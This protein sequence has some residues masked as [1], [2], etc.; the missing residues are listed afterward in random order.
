MPADL[1]E[2]QFA[3]PSVPASSKRQGPRRGAALV[4]VLLVILVA[5]G[6]ATAMVQMAV[7]QRRQFASD[8]RRAQADWFAQAGLDRAVAQL[9]MTPDYTG[10]TWTIAA[11]AGQTATVTIAIDRRS[12]SVLATVVA[13]Y[14]VGNVRR[15]RCRREL[16]LASTPGT[17][18][19]S[20]LQPEN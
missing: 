1:I 11:V 14:P 3:M 7:Q 20:A 5:T 16:T 6:I 9:A 17:T 4:I 19:V 10:E 18:A 2:D 12:D 15:A 8:L 13:E